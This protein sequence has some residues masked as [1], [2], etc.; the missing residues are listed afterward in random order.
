MRKL[1]FLAVTAL[2]SAA[3]AQSPLNTLVGGTNS[4]NVGGGIYFDLT[5]NTTVTFTRIDYYSSVATTPAGNSTCDIYLGPPTYVGNVTNLALWAPVAST[6]PVA[7]PA[8]VNTLV[9]GVLATPFAL[10]PG[11]YGV[12]LKA[13]GH[14]WAY[15]N[16]NGTAV[17]GSGTNQTFTTAEM[18]L[19]AGAAQ[20]AFLTGGIFTPRVWN[21]ALHYTNGGSPVVVANWTPFGNGCYKRSKSFYEFW[22]SSVF[23]DFG[24]VA[25]GG[26]GITSVNQAFNGA[27]YA[28]TSGTNTLVA[29]TSP[30]LG[31]GDDVTQVITLAGGSP[32]IVFQGPGG[33]T[34]ASSVEMCS[35]GYLTFN[36]TST[37]TAVPDPTPFLAGSPIIGNW[38]DFDPSQAGAGTHY[39]FN[40]AVSIGGAAG[41]HIFTWL[42]CP[43]FGIAATSNNYQILIDGAG[44]LEHR[45]GAMSQSGGGGWPTVLGFSVGGGA[46]NPGSSDLSARLP[47]NNDTLDSPPL[48]LEMTARPRLNTTP[49][50]RITGGEAPPLQAA[51]LLAVSLNGANYPNGVSLSG[52]PWLMPECRDYIVLLNP[53]MVS[54]FL[55]GNP[56]PIQNFTIPA[57][58]QYNG[59]TVFAQAFAISSSFNTTGFGVGASASNGV[60]MVAGSL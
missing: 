47:F 26:S 29:P 18:T 35:N 40:P 31:L 28:L 13:N 4:G 9:Q 38:H 49:G 30:S 12:A 55:L 23:V 53:T 11:T 3:F 43:D 57:G 36:G 1:A 39:E 10:G 54:F 48:N 17:P 8:A 20:N 41:C 58:P 59:V 16:G 22:P 19:R 2:A 46:Y 56:A 50:F 42:N 21:G 15:T 5:I 52:P 33:I 37:P 60:R 27:R 25:A 24:T 51:A 44:N 14:S 34:I 45:W 32:P 6:N 7:V